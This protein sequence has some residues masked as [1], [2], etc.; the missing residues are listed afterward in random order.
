MNFKNSEYV[1]LMCYTTNMWI[2][3][4]LPFTNSWN[5]DIGMFVLRSSVSVQVSK[6]IF[7]IINKWG[8]QFWKCFKNHSYF[9]LFLFKFILK[10]FWTC[11]QIFEKKSWPVSNWHNLDQSM[12]KRPGPNRVKGFLTHL[13]PMHLF[14]NPWYFQWVEKACFENKWVNI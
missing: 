3:F 12:H 9:Y 5:F 6:K 13:F 2:F 4:H 1:S 8:V 10:G 14:C 11:V 7:G